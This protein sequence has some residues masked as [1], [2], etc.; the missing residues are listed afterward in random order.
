MRVL[1]TGANGFLGRVLC[2]QLRGEH[3]NLITTDKTGDNIDYL[4]DLSDAAFVSSLP[5]VEVILHLASVQYVTP[6]LPLFFRHTFFVKNNVHAAQ[7]LVNRY[8]GELEYFLN[9][10]TS[11]LYEQ[12]DTSSYAVT[13]TKKPSGIYSQTKLMALKI[14]QSI[15]AKNQA[16]LYP[17]IILGKGREGLFRGFIERINRYHLVVFPGNCE[18]KTAVVHVND[19]ANT[20][21]QLLHKKAQ[22]DFNV[23]ANEALS[24]KQWVEE[25]ET[26]LNKKARYRFTIPLWVIKIGAF[27]TA[28]RILAKEQVLMLQYPHVLDIKENYILNMPPNIQVNQCICDITNY[29]IKKHN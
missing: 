1:V 13:A 23:M 10:S 3:V 20:I 9:V 8:Q 16:N 21:V 5:D 15:E 22:G 14:L 2:Q 18:H 4:G 11:M 29:F 27:L 28:Y 7:N 26:C 19:V 25:I 17:C 12:K 24:I 6:N